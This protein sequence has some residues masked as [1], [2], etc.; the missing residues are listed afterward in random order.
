[1]AVNFHAGFPKSAHFFQECNGVEHHAIAN[2]TATAVAQHAARHELQHELLAF[3]DD[4]VAGVVSA[5]IAGYDRKVFG[6]DID[7][8]ALALIAPLGANDDRSFSLF[9]FQLRQGFGDT[10]AALLPESH[11]PHP[12]AA[13]TRVTGIRAEKTCTQYLSV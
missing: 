2:N 1:M 10:V 8:L 5:G 13:C 3:N 7:N 11:T 9:H 4:R 12:R 6:E